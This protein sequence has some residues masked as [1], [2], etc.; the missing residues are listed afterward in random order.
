MRQVFEKKW[1]K[2]AL[3]GMFSITTL[4]SG[5][6]MAM[7]TDATLAASS[8]ESVSNIQM[9]TTKSFANVLPNNTGISQMFHWGHPGIDITAPL[10][11]T[12]YPLKDGVVIRMENLK[13]DYGRAVYVDHGNGLVT[14]YAH[15]GKVFVEEGEKITTKMP[16]GEVGLT[17]RTTG[18]HLHFELRKDEV[19]VNPLPFLD[20]GVAMAR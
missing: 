11:T 7:P 9:E 12:I 15:M 13:W 5:M 2:T 10:G 14:L 19:A 4:A 6:V 8:M 18:P 3:G 17:G 1:I 16:I 20:L